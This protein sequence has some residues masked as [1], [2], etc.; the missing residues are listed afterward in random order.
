MWP[1]VELLRRLYMGARIILSF[2]VFFP[3]SRFSKPRSLLLSM[4]EGGRVLLR[5]QDRAQ[6][7]KEERKL[8]PACMSDTIVRNGIRAP[9]DVL[10]M[11]CTAWGFGGNPPLALEPGALVS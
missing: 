10:Y 5:S 8:P 4:E 2:F 6:E 7:E 9:P 11:L 1:S 3:G